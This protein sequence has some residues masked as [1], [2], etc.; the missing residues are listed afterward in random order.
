[1][2]CLRRAL[3]KLR[4]FVGGSLGNPS[5]SL[6]RQIDELIWMCV[7]K[8]VINLKDMSNEHLYKGNECRI[9]DLIGY[10]FWFEPF[11]FEQHR[12]TVRL[13]KLTRAEASSVIAVHFYLDAR[14]VINLSGV[15]SSELR[16][17]RPRILDL[18]TV[19]F[20]SRIMGGIAKQVHSASLS[21]RA[22][23]RNGRF[24]L[25]HAGGNS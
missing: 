9:E 11:W 4:L 17:F 10:P 1:M 14:A 15:D 2:R 20:A 25:A 6:A 19:H 3:E 21:D 7:N 23:K 18:N 16:N 24:V 12:S 8:L 5:P 13:S 22:C